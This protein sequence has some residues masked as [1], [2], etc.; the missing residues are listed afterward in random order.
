MST[1]DAS[2][3]NAGYYN[4]TITRTWTATD[5]AGNADNCVQV[6][7]VQDVTDPVITCPVDVT[8]NC[9]DD[10]TPTGTGTATATDNCAPVPNITIGYSDVSTQDA[11]PANAGYYNYT[12]TRTWMATDPAGN[13]DNCVQVIT[14]QMLRTLLSRVP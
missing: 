6:I 3:A 9:E 1:Q 7:T 11:S 2:P 10:N 4:Y 8:I 14:V 13:A 5:P 12:I